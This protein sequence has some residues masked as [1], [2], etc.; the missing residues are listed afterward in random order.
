MF[1]IFRYKV[2][3]EMKGTTVAYVTLEPAGAWAYVKVIDVTLE[4]AGAWAYVKVID[5]TRLSAG[6]L[7]RRERGPRV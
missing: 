3:G 1:E 4:P 7:P 2:A 5:V 6:L